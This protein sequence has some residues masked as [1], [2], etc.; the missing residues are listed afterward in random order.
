[1]KKRKKTL[2]ENTPHTILKKNTV[3]MFQG[4]FAL[5]KTAIKDRNC[6][7]SKIKEMREVW[8]RKI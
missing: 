2:V 7:I 8:E 5:F 6:R 3:M 4:Q 1:M